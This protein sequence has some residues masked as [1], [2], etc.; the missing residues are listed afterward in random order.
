MKKYL[1]LLSLLLVQQATAS[2]VT[3]YGYTDG[4]TFNTQL[5]TLPGQPFNTATLGD[6][7]IRS[8]VDMAGAGGWGI[9][10]TKNGI[11][12]NWD[13]TIHRTD[14]ALFS[15]TDFSLYES[16]AGKDT[17]TITGYDSKGT[18]TASVDVSYIG[19]TTY[20]F[21]KLDTKNP[22]VT[23]ARIWGSEMTLPCQISASIP[24]TIIDINKA[25]SNVST[26]T[27]STGRLSPT[28]E[29][30][31]LTSPVPINIPTWGLLLF[32]MAFL[33]GLDRSNKNKLTA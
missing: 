27:I 33:W 24:C 3:N 32:G 11:P 30:L 12:S 28:L 4:I 20:L 15:L 5:V 14:N 1:M 13:M 18:K 2:V 25:L 23:D 31:R 7:S 16:V 26:L 22:T 21:N 17:I 9:N 29:S 19:L 8:T 6:Y 10:F